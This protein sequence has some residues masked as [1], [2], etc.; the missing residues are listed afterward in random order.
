MKIP[1]SP[2]STRLSDSAKETELRLRNIFQWKKK[3][4]PVVAM[5]LAALAALFCGGLVSCQPS[6]AE[7]PD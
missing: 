2:F 4:P 3:R 7:L 5:I 6:G 1:D